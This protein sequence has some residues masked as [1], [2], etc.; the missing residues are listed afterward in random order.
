[1]D[2]RNTRMED[3]TQFSAKLSNWARNVERHLRRAVAVKGL[4]SSRSQPIAQMMR[5][6]IHKQFSEVS[7]TPREE[8]TMQVFYVLCFLM[9][10][11]SVPA[12]AADADQNLKQE[13]E[14]VSSAYAASFNK[15][16]GAGIAALYARDGIYVNSAGPRTDLADIYQGV[17]KAGFDH[18]ETTVKQVWPLGTDTALVL[19]EC[20]RKGRRQ[21]G[22][23]QECRRRQGGKRGEARARAGL[24]L[25]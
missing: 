19:G 4:H 2:C 20:R 7:L 13:I 5:M 12:A 14:K 9:A 1:M 18:M 8:N 21:D 17:W 3:T 11:L 6:L 25:H 23:D 10:A 22:R 16:D 15:H 24:G